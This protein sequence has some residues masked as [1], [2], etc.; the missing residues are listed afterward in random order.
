L[1]DAEVT[2]IWCDRPQDAQAVARSAGIEHCVNRPADVIGYVDAVIIPTDKGEE[3]LERARPFI[4]AGVPVFI[5]KPLA[6]RTDH[7]D[8]FVAWKREGKLICSTSAMRYA[9][10]FLSLR[11]RL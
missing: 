2:H 8:Q 5:D 4:E 7:L 3:H 10:E 1:A 6:I 9:Q 11:S